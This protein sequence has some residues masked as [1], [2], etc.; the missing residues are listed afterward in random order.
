VRLTI[1]PPP[2]AEL[3]DYEARLMLEGSAGRARLAAE[4]TVLRVRLRAL[5]SSALAIVLSGVLLAA[6][7]GAIAVSRRLARR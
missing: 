7:A 5:K 4:P 1:V 3:G 2:N 6:A